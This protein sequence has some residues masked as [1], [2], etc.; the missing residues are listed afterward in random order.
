MK[1]TVF[2][3]VFDRCVLEAAKVLAEEIDEEIIQQIM[4]ENKQSKFQ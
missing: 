3:L 1:V 4:A 2:D